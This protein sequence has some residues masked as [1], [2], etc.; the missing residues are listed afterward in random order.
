MLISDWSSDVCSSDLLGSAQEVFQHQSLLLPTG[1]RGELP[2][3]RPVVGDVEGGHRADVPE[4][5]DV[6]AAG[7]GELGESARIGHLVLLVVDL[8]Q[9]ELAPVH[10]GGGTAYACG[11]D[12]KSTRLNSSH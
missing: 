4:H 9:R 3:L 11:R 2:I 1:E 5:L 8:H 7:V 12:R 10:L 6:I